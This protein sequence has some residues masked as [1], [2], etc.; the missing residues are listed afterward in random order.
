MYQNILK[1]I[2]FKKICNWTPNL[3]IQCNA[4][5]YI[6]IKRFQAKVIIDFFYNNNILECNEIPDIPFPL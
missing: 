1:I 5:T 3:V 2:S 6:T 4:H